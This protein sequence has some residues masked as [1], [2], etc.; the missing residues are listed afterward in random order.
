MHW[1]LRARW[2]FGALVFCFVVVALWTKGSISNG[3]HVS[4]P[5]GF[6]AFL[7]YV[8]AGLAVV[9]VVTYLKNGK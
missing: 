2:T 6:I 8:C 7:P 3:L 1:W 9:S 4:G 5:S